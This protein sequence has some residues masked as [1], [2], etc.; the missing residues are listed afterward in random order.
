M[1][2]LGRRKE[3]KEEVMD[4]ELNTRRGVY[5]LHQ[6]DTG[7]SEHLRQEKQGTRLAGSI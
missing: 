5:L 4:D 6:G 2:E 1:G 3:E 7:Q